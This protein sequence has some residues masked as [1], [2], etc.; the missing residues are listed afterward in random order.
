MAESLIENLLS[1]AAALRG[2]PCGAKSTDS[3][4][5][6]TM[7]LVMQLTSLGSRKRTRARAITIHV[8]KRCG[9]GKDESVPLRLRNA[10]GDAVHVMAADIA[11]QLK[12]KNAD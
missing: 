3:K 8:C 9:K 7:S 10:L 1:S 11:R 6:P 4:G 2:C 5:A 12:D